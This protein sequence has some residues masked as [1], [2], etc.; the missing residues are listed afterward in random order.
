MRPMPVSPRVVPAMSPL[1]RRVVAIVAGTRIGLNMMKS[2]VDT[3]KAT[4][5]PPSVT[6]ENA[7]QTKEVTEAIIS[8]ITFS[9]GKIKEN[10][11]KKRLNID[12]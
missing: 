7:K 2:G 1:A 6:Q 9:N 11:L 12:A 3:I 4:A 8:F 5:E 10:I